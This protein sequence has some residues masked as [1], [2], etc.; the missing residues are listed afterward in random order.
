[1]IDTRAADQSD[2][3]TA[4]TIDEEMGEIDSLLDE[5]YAKAVSNR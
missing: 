3:A 5:S 4:A 1:M 2:D